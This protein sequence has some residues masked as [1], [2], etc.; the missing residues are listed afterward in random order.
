MPDWHSVE[1]RAIIAAIVLVANLLHELPHW[2][3]S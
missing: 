2:A 1:M 3:L